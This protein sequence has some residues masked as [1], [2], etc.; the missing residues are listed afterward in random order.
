SSLLAS[1]A[2]GAVLLGAVGCSPTLTSKA[3]NPVGARAPERIP[4][5]QVHFTD[6]TAKAGIR[7]HHV[8][9]AFGQKL[10]PET[11]GSGVAFLDYDG[12]GKQDLLF[13][14]S[15]SWPGHEDKSRP[16][17]TMALYRNKGDGTFEDVTDTAGLACTFYGMGV[18]VADYDNDGWPDLFIHGVGA[19]HFFHNEPGAKGGRHFV[20][21]TDKAGVAGPGGWPISSGNFL[22]MQSPLNWST[23]AAFLDYDGDGRLDLFVCN[24]V[25]WSPKGDLVQPFQLQGVGRAYGPPTSFNVPHCFLSHNQGD[26]TFEEGTEKAGILVTG[27]PGAMVGKSLGVVVCD[28]DHDGWPDIVVANDTVRNFFFHNKGDGTFEELGIKS[29]IAYAEPRA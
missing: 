4:V 14:N 27:D 16:V 26:G 3:G 21:V 12:D 25:E 24:Y 17:P 6:I 2:V 1:L 5:P 22:E 10:L 19:N 20:E 7:F 11:M 28:V 8:N 29:G 18:T 13:I 9:G 15:C 23:S